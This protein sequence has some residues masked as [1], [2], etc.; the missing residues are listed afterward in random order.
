MAE[1]DKI[2]YSVAEWTKSSNDSW[3]GVRVRIWINRWQD[4]GS[5][6]W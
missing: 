6:V 1:N 2:T 4:P 3:N 5:L